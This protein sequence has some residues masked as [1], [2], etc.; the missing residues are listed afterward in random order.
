MVG[1]IW[2][3]VLGEPWEGVR[4]SNHTRGGAPVEV[5]L[6]ASSQQGA[7]FSYKGANSI[8]RLLSL[9]EKNSSVESKS[10]SSLIHFLGSLISTSG[11][12]K[13][14]FKCSCDNSWCIWREL[15]E[16]LLPHSHCNN[17]PWHLLSAYCL[18]D[19]LPSTLRM[20]T[21]I[22]LT[23]LMKWEGDVY[24]TFIDE[25]AERQTGK[26]TCSHSHSK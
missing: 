14:K 24:P 5:W 1:R 4:C 18:P 19:N 15:Y 20:L 21:H 12:R 26:I 2:W 10:K 13:S 6:L 3:T 9:F 23:R 8:F 16:C 7:P 11:A 25:E 17:N 22:I